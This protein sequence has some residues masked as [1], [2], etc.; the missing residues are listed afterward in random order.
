[1]RLDDDDFETYDGNDEAAEVLAAL[2]SKVT[3][4]EA[5]DAL[6]EFDYDIDAA[7]KHLREKLAKKQQAAEKRSL[8]KQQAPQKQQQPKGKS[9]LQMLAEERSSKEQTPSGLGGLAKL[10]KSKD[11]G[12]ESALAKLRKSTSDAKGSDDKKPNGL[13]ALARL[14]A[15][16]LNSTP[17]DNE[18][19]QSA[20]PQDTPKTTPVHT[21]TP[22]PAPEPQFY[23]PKF[24]HT[25]RPTPSSFGALLGSL[26]RSPFESVSNSVTTT[27]ETK[28]NF[29]K[30]SPD[31]KVA[32]A[33]KAAFNGPPPTSSEK[34]ATPVV[35]KEKTL[36]DFSK[37]SLKPHTSFV[38]I[39]HVDAG[40]STLMGRLLLDTGAV[41]KK[42]I[43]NHQRESE[44]IGKSSFALAWVMDATQ[45]ER[46]RGVTIDVGEASFET[47]THRFTVVDAPGHCDYVPNMIAGVAQAD[48]AVLVV[49]SDVNAFESG[50]SLDGQT[51]EHAIL[52]RSLGIDSIIVAVNKL[53]T[54]KWS[55]DRFDDIK[56]QLTE[57]LGKTVGFSTKKLYFVPTS[58]KEGNYVLKQSDVAPWYSGPTL[59]EAL[60]N[61]PVKQRDYNAPFRFIASNVYTEDY[62]STTTVAGRVITGAVEQNDV[63]IN[64]SG[65][66]RTSGVVKSLP[67]SRDYCLA[68]EVV[69][70]KTTIPADE[71][72]PGDV[73]TAPDASLPQVTSFTAKII[74]F[75]THKPILTGSALSFYQGRV[76]LQVR[77][78][79]I[80]ASLDKKGEIIKKKPR[81]LT[82]GQAAR[83]LLKLEKP[84]VL[85]PYN[86]IRDLGRFVLRLDGA[87][88]GGGVIES[89]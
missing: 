84:T 11:S 65:I 76:N 22:E 40:K 87:T 44:K 68:G 82:K 52:A 28:A 2:G 19:S 1:M 37:L 58:G 4:D 88:I 14:R 54:Q 74:L 67:E 9:K 79:K 35:K 83:V 13:S 86:E 31:D 66:D 81:H 47:K 78:S 38:V 69:E 29:G 12:G 27:K 43:E 24:E 56:T 80:E 26:L 10:R 72:R 57:Y 42:V 48:V 50:F 17:N 33:Q 7:I 59:V 18:K 64:C 73:L 6:E 39:G 70:L 16:K 21:P 34:P 5:W 3:E 30:P 71:C 20:T 77:I 85:A 23:T 60:E 49:D 36:P 63:I 61:I 45:E 51:K 53:D 8:Q 15:K 41:S 25:S 32:A 89:T 46:Q 55:E 62:Q 75:D